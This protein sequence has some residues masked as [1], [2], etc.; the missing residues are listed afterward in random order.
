[1]GLETY[2]DK[3]NTRVTDSRLEYRV[4]YNTSR[5]GATVR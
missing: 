1:M 2:I 4:E 5:D 3:L